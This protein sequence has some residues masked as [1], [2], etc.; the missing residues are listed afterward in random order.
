MSSLRSS[1]HSNTYG[2]LSHGSGRRTHGTRLQRKNSRN[3][4]NKS[5]FGLLLIELEIASPDISE[6]RKSLLTDTHVDFKLQLQEYI[7][8][9]EMLRENAKQ[10]FSQF[11]PI[12]DDKAVQD[13]GTIGKS[14][15]RD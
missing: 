13:L 6:T 1:V 5:Q 8:Q 10:A 9:M 4:D 2:T 3:P 7:Q 14:R 11:L 15:K 12:P